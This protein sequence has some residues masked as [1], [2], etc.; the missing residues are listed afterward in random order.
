MIVINARFLTQQT[1]G[2]QRFAEQISL[3]LASLR[4]D[5]VFVTPANIT[6][7]ETAERLNARVIGHNRGHLWEQLDLPLWLLR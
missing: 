4:D 2:V 5:L 6:R 3:E 1:R 7:H